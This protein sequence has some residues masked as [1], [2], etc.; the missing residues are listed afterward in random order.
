MEWMWGKLPTCPLVDNV[1]DVDAIAGTMTMITT[2]GTEFTLT[3][4]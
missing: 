1:T 3:M 4:K 2:K